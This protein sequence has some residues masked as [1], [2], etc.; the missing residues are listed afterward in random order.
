MRYIIWR[1][2]FKNYNLDKFW[3]AQKKNLCF[4][5]PTARRR[6]QGD[7]T[8]AVPTCSCENADR[9]RVD[10]LKKQEDLHVNVQKKQIHTGPYDFHI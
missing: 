7:Q 1:V 6:P 5:Q 2:D 3:P 9:Q 8:K 10:L 4:R